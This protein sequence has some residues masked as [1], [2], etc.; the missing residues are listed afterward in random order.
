VGDHAYWLSGLTARQSG[1][2]GQIDALSH[3]FGEGDPTPSGVQNGTG[4]L[5]GG[6]F[7][8]INYVSQTQTWGATP[9][10]PFS[11][12]VDITATNIAT[13]VINVQRARL[14]CNAKVNFVSTDGPIAVTLAGC[15][16]V[17]HGG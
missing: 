10:A 17:V 8:A 3:G 12:S 14:D 9:T 1:S 6:N 4:A 2:E 13:A 7:G 5:T 11:D 15:N 16:R